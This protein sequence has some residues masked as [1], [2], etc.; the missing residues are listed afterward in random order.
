MYDHNP[1]LFGLKDLCFFVVIHCV[2]MLGEQLVIIV[3]RGG[4]VGG[5]RYVREWC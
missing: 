1:S 3:G 2:E 5:L 4:Y